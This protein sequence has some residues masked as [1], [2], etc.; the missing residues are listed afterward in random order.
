MEIILVRHGQPTVALSTWISGNQLLNFLEQ[1]D[2][3][4][5]ASGS[6]P[7]EKTQTLVQRSALTVTSDRQR[8]IHSAK[9]LYPDGP[10]ISDALFRE[11]DCWSD[12]PFQYRL[13]AIT[14]IAMSRWLWGRG[15]GVGNETP[16]QVIERAMQAAQYLVDA[17][18]RVGYVTL[19]GHGGINYFI[20][21][22][23]RNMDW[24]GSQRFTVAHW[25]CMYFSR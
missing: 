20:G 13:P 14:W 23:L 7:S 16:Q 8:T 12:M 21:Q 9:I 19:V 3:A 10:T 11:T 5:V 1:Y 17:A 2:R 4:G 24:K 25:S 6:L 22:E 15:Y 18:S